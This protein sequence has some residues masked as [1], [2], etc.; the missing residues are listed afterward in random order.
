MGSLALG[1]PPIFFG[2]LTFTPDGILYATVD[3]GGGVLRYDG[4]TTTALIPSGAGQSY[5]GI[6]SDGGFLYVSNKDTG[7]L[8][9][10]TDAGVFVADVTGGPGAFDI[11]AMAV[12]EPRSGLLLLAGLAGLG[13]WR[14]R[15]VKSK[16]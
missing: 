16:N 15:M 5:W 14:R 4:I 10:Y 9:I 8:K 6:L 11:I 2:D 13:L 3:G 12:P 1:T 7:T